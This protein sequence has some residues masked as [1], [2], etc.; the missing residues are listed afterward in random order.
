MGMKDTYEQRLQAKLEEWDAEIA[1]LK[2]K[3]G[4][5]EAAAQTQYKQELEDLQERRKE[6]EAKLE[7]LRQ[8]GEGAWED[9]KAG[10]ELSKDSLDQAIRS[11]RAR[12]Q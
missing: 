8:S 6:L 11:A 2:V 7:E 3:A 1:K 12:F 4:E 5:V 10:I 9:I